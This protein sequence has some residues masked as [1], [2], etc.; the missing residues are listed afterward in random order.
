[1]LQFSF[2]VVAQQQENVDFVRGEVL[3][4]PIPLEKKIKGV[5]TYEFKV[6]Q[7]VD[8]V[9]LDA[10]KIEFSSVLLNRKRVRYISDGKTVTIKKNFKKG[11]TYFLT[12]KY[13]A[14]PKQAL[15]FMHASNLASSQELLTKRGQ[16]PVTEY[17]RSENDESM[18]NSVTELNQNIVV[19]RNRNE[20]W[21]Q[22]QGKYTSHWLPS[23]D[24]MNEKVQFD[25][26]ITFDSSY[27]VIANGKLTGNKPVLENTIMWNFD[28]EQP[29][30]SYLLAFVIGDFDKKIATSTSGIPLE[31]YYPK[32]DSLLAEPTYRYTKEIFDFMENEIGVAYPWQNYKQVP[33]KDF[34]YGGMENTGTTIFSNGY[35]IDSIAFVDKNYVN[36]NAHELAHQWFGN[37][38]TEVDGNHHW[39]HEGFATYYALLAEK[40]IFG[41]D[42]F[43]WELYDTAQKLNAFTNENGGE[44]L[45]NPKAS[46]LTFYQKG[47]WALFMLKEQIGAEA[48]KKGI[49]A[50]LEK[51]QFKNVTITHF[52]LEMEDASG[53]DLSA[54]E[55]LW[56]QK[57]A[58]PFKEALKAL[59]N[60]SPSIA[61]FLKLKKEL[62]TSTEANET[63]I[64][65]YWEKT[66]S[67]PLKKIIV[68]KYFSS[69][70][71][72]FIKKLFK[73]EGLEVRQAVGFAMEQIPINLK[74]EYELLLT[75]K[76][77][78]TIENALYK[79]WIYFPSERKKYLE[80]TKNVVGMPN[81]NV[82]LLWLTLAI[83]TKDYLVDNQTNYK[84]ELSGYTS[85]A[86]SFEVRQSAFE[87]LNQVGVLSKQNLIDLIQASNHHSWQFKK[88]ARNLIDTLLQKESYKKQLVAL[89][90]ELKENTSY[91]LKKIEEGEL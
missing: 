82:R 46:S 16:N 47:A 58:F 51:H 7:A 64:I 17:S 70:S 41:A 33:V 31:M 71:E 88:Y 57:K 53:V 6:L 55:A 56:L 78:Y 54:Y 52:L 73:N 68:S 48:F 75:A 30:S 20:I 23:F 83:I 21:T 24:D 38:V 45:I 3:V 18:Q 26:N 10:K 60:V 27:T 90:K 28:M 15:Y 13:T 72:N 49:K 87:Y 50:Y 79:L 29:M 40:E 67:I 34:L 80:L 19:E 36:V 32:K 59:K 22:G 61:T 84:K 74:K 81:K 69:L 85:P 39:L 2:F 4:E 63:I 37:L 76:S 9:F 12:L 89:A 14:K 35:V 11:E 65:R 62:T 1:M 44:A 86:Y 42:Y 5:V 77:Y 25:L 66:K 91:V 43:Y 8:S